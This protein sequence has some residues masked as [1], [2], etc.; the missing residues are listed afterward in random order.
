MKGILHLFIDLS[1]T[2]FLIGAVLVYS[3]FNYVR[4]TYHDY[5]CVIYF[6]ISTIIHW[7]ESF[8]EERSINSPIF[9]FISLVLVGTIIFLRGIKPQH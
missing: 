8:D 4:S 1:P 2:Y 6:T 3:A 7:V 9:S 5:L